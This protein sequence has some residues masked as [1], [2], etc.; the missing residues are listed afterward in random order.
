MLN[1]NKLAKGIKKALDD[2]ERQGLAGR[3]KKPD[4]PHEYLGNKIARAID[5]YIREADVKGEHKV[6][7]LKM[8]LGVQT[9]EYAPPYATPTPG[10]TLAMGN[11]ITKTNEGPFG[12]D[13]FPGGNG[14]IT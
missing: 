14:K 9:L 7:S 5:I 10:T 4:D 8:N 6:P 12:K 2:M 3:F 11:P 13:C 1:K